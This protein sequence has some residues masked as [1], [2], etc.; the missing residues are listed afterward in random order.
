LGLG[1]VGVCARP[2]HIH[3]DGFAGGVD[4]DPVQDRSVRQI[5]KIF[6]DLLS[7][8]QQVRMGRL[9]EAG[10]GAVGSIG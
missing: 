9:V 2:K 5:G 1:A 8:G 10:L 4:V 7:T 3:S 6:G